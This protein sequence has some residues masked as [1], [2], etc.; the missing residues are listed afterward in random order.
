MTAKATK[1]TAGNTEGQWRSGYGVKVSIDTIVKRVYL[2]LRSW[3]LA[4]DG[5]PHQPAHRKRAGNPRRQRPPSPY[6]PGASKKHTAY[7]H[8]TARGFSP[9]HWGCES[10]RARVGIGT[11]R[12]VLVFCGYSPAS[13]T[14]HTRPAYPP[15]PVSI[16]EKAG[17]RLGW[18]L[19]P[20]AEGPGAGGRHGCPVKPKSQPWPS[21]RA[22]G[23]TEAPGNVFL[24]VC[25]QGACAD[26][27]HRVPGFP[28]KV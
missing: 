27:G 11:G 26:E 13:A 22:Y 17:R 16:R 2:T 7:C 25:L 15:G 12:W 6:L 9:G 1:G 28:K 4:G 10:P 8:G 23:K 20:N 3:G 18:V 19:G 14:P 24:A 21:R 5:T